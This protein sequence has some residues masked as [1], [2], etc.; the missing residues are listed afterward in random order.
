MFEVVPMIP[1]VSCRSCEKG[2]EKIFLFCWHTLAQSGTLG[3]T[4]NVK[5]ILHRAKNT[6]EV[7]PFGVNDPTREVLATD[8]ESAEA[9]DLLNALN[10]YL[11]FCR[12]SPEKQDKKEAL[13][14]PN[15]AGFCRWL[16]CSFSELSLLKN[17]RP[18]LYDRIC[19]VLEDEALNSSLSASVLTA[20]L[21]QRLWSGE[22]DVE[23]K[24]VD[25]SE[26]LRLVFEH[27]ILEDGS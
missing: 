4:R 5:I 6:K 14:F 20:Y 11:Q 13:P 18:A 7:M 24:A 10:Q 2:D 19:T 17:D 8:L 3:T 16:G 25:G 21:K 26:H 1:Q 27:D 12:Q 22:K 23:K 9:C 15:L